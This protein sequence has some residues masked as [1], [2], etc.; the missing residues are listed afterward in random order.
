MAA[1]LEQTDARNRLSLPSP[2]LNLFYFGDKI[3]CRKISSNGVT[4]EASG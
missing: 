2:V 3:H 1:V 4:D